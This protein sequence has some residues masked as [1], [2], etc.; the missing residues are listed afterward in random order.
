MKEIL[1][2]IVAVAGAAGLVPVL[3]VLWLH[4]RHRN[5]LRRDL[6]ALRGSMERQQMVCLEMFSEVNRT[7]T[8]L[9]EGM[10][11]LRQNPKSGTL[12][13]STRAQAMKLLRSGVSA[14]AAASSLGVGRR[15]IRLLENVSQILCGR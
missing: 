3:L 7:L 4:R 11:G 1:I 9:E 12:N 14:D 15:E 2:L 10:N 6:E 5:R 8:T 13:R